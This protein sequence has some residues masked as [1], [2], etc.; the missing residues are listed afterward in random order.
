MIPSSSFV[1]P[2]PLAHAD[3]SRD[4]LQKRGTSQGGIKTALCKEL[5]NENVDG[6]ATVAT[7]TRVF[8]SPPAHAYVALSVNSSLIP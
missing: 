1:I 8:P 7:A 2:T 5:I 6:K 4:V 3:T